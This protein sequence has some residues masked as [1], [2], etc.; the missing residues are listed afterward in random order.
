MARRKDSDALWRY[1]LA[2]RVTIEDQIQGRSR[3][4]IQKT[5]YNKNTSTTSGS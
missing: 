1:L 4:E 5:P 2:I 3:D